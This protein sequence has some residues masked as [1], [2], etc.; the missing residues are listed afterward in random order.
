MPTHEPGMLATQRLLAA[1]GDFTALFAFNDMSAIG[2]VRALREAGRRVPGDVSVVGFDDVQA[3]AFQ[4]P[5]LTTVRQPLMQ[6]GKLAAETLLEQMVP[7]YAGTPAAELVVEP[8]L[9]VRES[10][11]AVKIG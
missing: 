6:M 2:A 3:A 10:T 9:A 11:A 4:N 5:S 8:E 7:G 1:D